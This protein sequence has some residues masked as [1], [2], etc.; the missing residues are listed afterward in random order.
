MGDERDDLRRDPAE[1]NEASVVF[2]PCSLDSLQDI[3]DE[4]L[5]EGGAAAIVKFIE[6]REDRPPGLTLR[7]LRIIGAAFATGECSPAKRWG[8]YKALDLD[9]ARHVTDEQIGDLY[10]VSKA[11]ISKE[12]RSWLKLLGLPPPPGMKSEAAC[13]SYRR[14]RL[15]KSTGSKTST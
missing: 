6:S 2:D 15:N 1:Y 9:I 14:V 3:V 5:E 12:A 10:A 8:L 4:L 11:A 13:A 7:Q